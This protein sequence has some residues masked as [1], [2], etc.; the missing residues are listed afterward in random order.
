MV[1]DPGSAGS[2]NDART[3]SDGTFTIGEVQL[4]LE[5]DYALQC[6]PANSFFRVALEYQ[7]WDGGNGF[8]EA[9]SFAGTT[10]NG[11]TN[12]GTFTASASAPEMNLFGFT[13]GTGLTW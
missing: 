7:R 11:A 2:T 13:L 8:S 5:W 3:H 4:G 1:D 12:Q 10:V 9:Q 6:I